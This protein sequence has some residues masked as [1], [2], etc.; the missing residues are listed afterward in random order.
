MSPFPLP[1]NSVISGCVVDTF[2]FQKCLFYCFR[3]CNSLWFCSLC[4]V[5]KKKKKQNPVLVTYEVQWGLTLKYLDRGLVYICQ[6]G[7]KASM[8]SQDG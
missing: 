4:L 2:C 7:P 3:G 1:N 8:S 6:Y 5:L